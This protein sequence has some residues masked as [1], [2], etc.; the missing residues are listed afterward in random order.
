MRQMTASEWDANV[1][2]YDLDGRRDTQVP[3]RKEWLSA[4]S[5][6][7]QAAGFSPQEAMATAKAELDG[8]VGLHGPDQFPGGNPNQITGFGDSG[9][10]SSLGSQWG[11]GLG[12]QLRAQIAR[13]IKQSG[14]PPEL[15]GDIRL[16]VDFRVSDVVN[17]GTKFTG[18]DGVVRVRP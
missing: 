13:M 2:H 10:N 1:R 9:V 5:E 15:L 3:Y 4:R 18:A 11:N 14:L 16:N 6:A 17:G 12:G 7:L 8:Q